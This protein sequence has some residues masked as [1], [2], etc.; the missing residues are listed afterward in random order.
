MSKKFLIILYGPQCSGKSTVAKLLLEKTPEVFHAS[1][2]KIKWFISDYSAEKYSGKGVINRLTLSLVNQAAAEGFS[3]LVE[4]NIKIMLGADEYNKIA[5]DNN[6]KF[7]QINIEAPYEVLLN[8]F[9]LRVK[10][11]Q[12]KNTKISVKTEDGMRERYNKY[13][14]LKKQEV[15]TFDSSTK[16]PEE[17]LSEIESLFK[18]Y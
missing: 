7:I 1:P 16:S 5:E 15:L 18:K 17:I 4:G 14:E 2:D 13:H 11:A 10:D 12:E 9:N 8:R 6:M 3:I